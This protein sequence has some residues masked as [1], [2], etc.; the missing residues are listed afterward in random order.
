MASSKTLSGILKGLIRICSALLLLAWL[1]GPGQAGFW[2][3]GFHLL[4]AV[5]SC[6]LASCLRRNWIGWGLAS[7]CVPLLPALWLTWRPSNLPRYVSASDN[8]WYNMERDVNHMMVVG[9]MFL[10][11]APNRETLEKLLSEKLLSFERF[12]QIPQM[13]DGVRQW[14]NDP[15]FNLQN[16][17]EYTPL[18][19][20]TAQAFSDRVNSLSGQKLDFTK[21]LWHMQVIPNHPSGAALVLR[22]HHCIADGIA[23]VR[24]LLSMTAAESSESGKKDDASL[25]APIRKPTPITGKVA[26]SL[27]LLWELI[28]AFPRMLMLPDSNTSFKRP[29]TGARRTAWSRP[30]PLETIKRIAQTHHAKINDVVLAATAGA[31]RRYFLL[32]NEPV[33]GITFRVLVP[34]NI[35]PLTGPIELGNKVGFIYLPLPVGIDNANERLHEVKRAMDAIKSGKEAFLSYLSLCFLGTLPQALQHSIIDIFNQ[36]ASSTMT[37]VPGP[38]DKLYFA[39]EAIRHMNFFGPQS[40]KMGVGISV[41]SYQDELTLGITAD[42]AM[43]PQPDIFTQCFEQEIAEWPL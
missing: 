13:R 8:C 17:L 32:H 43:V 4:I 15:H 12:R 41:F 1:A 9:L 7:L 5:A 18:P 23:L 21:P 37:N 35:R 11:A 29:L 14:V 34:I 31:L 36:N 10:D 22:I 6:V 40:G 30:L 19:E 16:H 20:P 2:L 39:G 28:E 38:R 27:T 24:V 25:A 42:A 26:G 3:T 33:K